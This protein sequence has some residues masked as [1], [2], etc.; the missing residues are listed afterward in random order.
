LSIVPNSPAEERGLRPNDR[1]LRIDGQPTDGW[2]E[3]LASARLLG[4]A[5]TSVDL[6][7]TGGGGEPPHTVRL[8]RQPLLVPS[9][10]WESVPR[11]GVGYVRVVSFQD[12]TVQEL[13][14]ALLHLQAAQMKALVLDLRGNSGGL[15]QSAVQV[16]ELFL[17]DG[18][19]VFTESPL[20]RFRG[21]YRAH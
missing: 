7:V 8:V 13:K 17:S 14:D 6:E 11:D 9:V 20:K 19:I 3:E 15:F 5:G 2:S 12:G 16:A 4:R 1:V 21:T 18:V 10:E